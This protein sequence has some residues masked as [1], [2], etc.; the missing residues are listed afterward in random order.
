MSTIDKTKLEK[1]AASLKLA[2]SEEE[3]TLLNPSFSRLE[4]QKEIIDELPGIENAEPM[5][6]PFVCSSPSLRED[7]PSTPLEVEEVLSNAKDVEE[8]QIKLPKVVG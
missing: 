2:L 8:N 6:F 7:E 1:F 5:I 3:Y 4:I